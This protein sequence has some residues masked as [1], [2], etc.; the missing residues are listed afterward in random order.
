MIEMAV[1]L[2]VKMSAPAMLNVTKMK[3]ALRKQVKEE[4]SARL[5]VIQ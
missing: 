4:I 2:S 5:F 3:F 1:I